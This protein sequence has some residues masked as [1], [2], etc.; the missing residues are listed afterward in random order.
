V[1][2]NDNQ[3]PAPKRPAR[4]PPTAVLDEYRGMTA[5]KETD[6]RRNQSDVRADQKALRQDQASLEKHLFAAPSTTW[7]QA[8]EKAAYLL[9][10]F[11]ATGEAQDPRYRHLIEDAVSDLRR[12]GGGV[13]KPVPRPR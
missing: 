9:G 12:L 11:A 1:G 6:V 3:S 4:L 2:E 8:A 13:T 5:Q 10:L 7:A